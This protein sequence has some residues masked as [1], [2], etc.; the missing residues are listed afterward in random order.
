LRSDHISRKQ[1]KRLN[2]ATIRP[3]TLNSTSHLVNILV[4]NNIIFWLQL[5]VAH[6]PFIAGWDDE[7][8]SIAFNQTLAFPHDSA[9][10]NPCTLHP[11]EYCEVGSV[12]WSPGMPMPSSNSARPGSPCYEEVPVEL[13]FIER[14]VVACCPMCTLQVPI[15]SKLSVSGGTLLMHHPPSEFITQAAK[16]PLAKVSLHVR[17]GFFAW[18]VL[19]TPERS[20][21]ADEWID[22]NCSWIMC[23]KFCQRK[24]PCAKTTLLRSQRYIAILIQSKQR[25]I[26]PVNPLHPE[27]G[28]ALETP[29]KPQCLQ[30]HN[31]A[32]SSN[33]TLALVDETTVDFI[34][35]NLKPNEQASI[36][37]LDETLVFDE[38]GNAVAGDDL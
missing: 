6:D 10:G 14:E 16:R 3:N 34:V 26:Q 20:F 17:Y 31:S 15:L 7:K 12:L 5:A 32:S 18:I 24:Y 9:V 28:V 21:E 36:L 4:C 35:N 33:V 38:Y 30:M 22:L 1:S 13:L 25:M 37:Y 23:L 27:L 19:P 8:A 29:T 2:E 11:N